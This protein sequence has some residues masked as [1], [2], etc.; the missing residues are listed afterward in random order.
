MHRKKMNHKEMK[1]LVLKVVADC[2][3]IAENYIRGWQPTDESWSTIE[4]AVYLRLS[5]DTQ[6]AVERGSLEQQI[7]IAISEAQCR[8][9]QE[10]L[11]Y[12]ITEFYIE[13]GITGTH[14]NRPEFIRLQHNISLKHHSFVIIK[15]IS[16]LVRDLEIWKRFFRL[17]QTYDCEICIRGLPFNPNDPAS[18]LQLD[19]LAAF[20]EFESRT[21]SKRIRESN[22]SALLTS[23]KFNGHFP[24]LGFDALKNEREEYT[25]IYKPNKEELRQVEWIMSSF[26]RVDRYKSLLELCK[27]R[28]IK[29]KRGKDFNRA[30]IK[31]LLTN[32][33]YIGKWYRNKHNADK[34]QSRLMAYERYTEIKLEHGCVINKGLWQMVQE[35]VKELDK[36]RAHA[37][38]HCYPLSGLLSYPDGSSFIGS[39][40]W[41][42]TRRSTYYHNIA[43]KIRVR[44]EVFESEAEKILR[45]VA[46]NS[47]EFRKSV[48]DYSSR[49]ES[50]IDLVVGKIT[51]V[52]TRLA[53][54]ATER[55]NLDNR[56]SFLLRDGDLE[57][58]NSFRD[59]YKK[60]FASLKKEEREL[61][62]RKRQ[63]QL[64]QKQLVEARDTG[65][66]G[67]LEQVNQALSCIKEKD[68]TS[69]RSIYRRLFQKVIV[70]PLDNTK[71][72]LEFIFNNV[73]TTLQGVVDTFCVPAGL[74]GVTGLEP[75]TSCSQSMRATNCAT[76]R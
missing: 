12:R 49:K 61:E 57:M 70:H 24:L 52:D 74:V 45:Q 41:G 51:E 54:M 63:L 9:E 17:C 2:R 38:K 31:T 14:D 8:S 23:G 20:A 19:Q 58:A 11:N 68:F 6:V 65:K 15:E 7:H 71:L 60:Q 10:R 33:R 48:A 1:E 3:A 16:R 29:N 75:A 59:E 34:R 44:T 42:R 32:P 53:T 66:S 73:S 18:I 43:N 25:G 5:D 64:L 62:N 69:L 46:N 26:L 72:Q 67:W 47:V 76:P 21:T 36:S 28:G 27:E 40:A 13:P 30:S 37:T 4:G 56:L 22:H 55:Q 35:K 50:S 39:S